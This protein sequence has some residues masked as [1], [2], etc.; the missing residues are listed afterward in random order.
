MKSPDGT[1]WI[2]RSM[3]WSKL[4]DEPRNTIARADPR[5]AMVV[6]TV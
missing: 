1:S 5:H 4:G 2:C 3:G 6:S